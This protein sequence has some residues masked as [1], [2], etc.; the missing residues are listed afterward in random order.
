MALLGA[1][2]A[3]G[4]GTVDSGDNFVPPDVSLDEDFFFC[5]IQPE[6]LTEHSCA[7]GGPGEQGSCHASVSA[8]RLDPMAE[9]QSVACEDGMPTGPI[10]PSYENNL[11]SVRTV[12]QPDPLR[13]PFYRRPI[14]LDSH[15]RVIFPEDSPEAMLISEWIRR[16]NM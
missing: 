13:S 8:L 4:C 11:T 6:V 10:P 3:A 7:S 12:V 5:R 1:V 16:G 14:G 9:S 15:P 2:L